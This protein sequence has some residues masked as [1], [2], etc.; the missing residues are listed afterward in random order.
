MNAAGMLG[1]APPSR[2]PVTPDALGAFVTHPISLAPRTPADRRYVMP[3]AGG[4][5]LHSGLPNPGLRAVIQRYA[6]RWAASP[7]PVVVHLLASTAEEAATMV[8]RLEGMEGVAAVELGLPPGASASQAVDLAL[9]A[10]GELPLVVCLPPE[11]VEGLAPALRSAG[12][13]AISLAAP[14]GTLIGP[15]GKPVSGRLYGP[16]VLPF[17]LAAVQAAHRAGFQV[18]GAGGIYRREQVDAMLQA[19]AWAVQLD[20]ILWQGGIG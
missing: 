4:F 12:V 9:A 20:G 16:A 19:G 1:F 2:G 5:L 11:A 7:I 14:R 13:F 10:Y 17:A 3:F 6:A 15:G 18:I 8:R